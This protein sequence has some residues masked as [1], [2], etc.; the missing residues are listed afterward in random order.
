[1]IYYKVTEKFCYTY[2]SK[3]AREPMFIEK[4]E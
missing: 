3:D 2:P 1:M 4:K